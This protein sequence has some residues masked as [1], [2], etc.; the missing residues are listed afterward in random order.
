VAEALKE[1]AKVIV[2]ARGNGYLRISMTRPTEEVE[3]GIKR[4]EE[5]WESII[6]K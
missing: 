1:K 5:V 3:E 6:K 2:G 4:I